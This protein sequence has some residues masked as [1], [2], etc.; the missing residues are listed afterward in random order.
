[1][2]DLSASGCWSEEHGPGPD[3]LKPMKDGVQ[4]RRLSLRLVG[5]ER[6]CEEN[7]GAEQRDSRNYNPKHRSILK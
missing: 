7:A 6:V 2:F 3:P 4:S 1:M 5:L